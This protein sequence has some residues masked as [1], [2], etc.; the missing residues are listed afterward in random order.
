MDDQETVDQPDA[1]AAPATANSASTML[2]VGRVHEE[3]GDDTDKS[4][5]PTDGSMPAVDHQRWPT[6]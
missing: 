5:A 6:R 4:L 3:R 1:I 2:P